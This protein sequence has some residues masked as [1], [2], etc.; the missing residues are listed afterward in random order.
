M[1]GPLYRELAEDLAIKMSSNS[2]LLTGHSDT[3][4]V[5]SSCGKLIISKAPTYNRKSKI[6]RIT[7]WI[8]YSM[9]AFWYMLRADKNTLIF[10]VI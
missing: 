6:T 3:L 8:R 2:M 9:V 4:A 5:G 7:S 10:L 1:A